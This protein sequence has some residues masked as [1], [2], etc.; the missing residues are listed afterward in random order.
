MTSK[1]TTD[2]NLSIN[3]VSKNSE[4][5]ELNKKQRLHIKNTISLCPECLDKI[6]AE[7]FT[8][9][10]SVYLS[11]Y[12]SNHGTFQDIYWS[13]FE[14]YNKFCQSHVVGT[15]VL[16]PAIK[17]EN[18]L[19]DCGLCEKH[20]TSTILAN[21]DV[22]NRCNL[23]CP[24]C[25]ANAKRSGFIYEPNEEQIQNMLLM[26][27]NQKPVPC[28]AVQF[29]GGEPTVR[30]DLPELISMAKDLDFLHI[31]IATNGV[32]IAKD[33]EFAHKLRTAGLQTV[34]LSF[35]GIGEE[36]YHITRG[37]NA[38]PLKNAAINNCRTA[39]IA[40][41]VLVPTLI[42][43]VNDHQVGNIINF[44][45]ERLDVIKGVNFQPVAFTG[46]IDQTER[47]KKRIT[48]PDFLLM[49]EEQTNGTICRDDWFS[50]PQSTSIS[51][52]IAAM[53]NKQVLQFTIHPHC[54]TVTY[55][56]KDGDKLIPITRFV[57]VDGLFEYLDEISPQ[58]SNTNFQIKKAG[59]TSK[60]LHKIS[61]FIDQKTAPQSIN[62]T[63]MIMDFFN[64]GTG[65]ALK[66][67]HRNSLFLGSMHFQDPYN[68]DIER[69][70]RCGIHYATPDGR[71]IPFCAYNTIHR[72]EVEAKFSKP[73]YS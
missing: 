44:A 14:L 59:L 26:L 13:D 28:C 9:D 62:V 23:N 4:T 12:C 57:D 43:E 15:G 35:D 19:L 30:D 11:K 53:L 58:I 34:Y 55:I 29:S 36:P 8:E 31:Q 70:Q 25:F 27:R 54:G 32:R 64:K 20:T 40:S 48:I 73:F 33:V 72:Q 41:I 39:G 17:S 38:F 24:V 60:A 10:G 50:V 49:T 46:R 56:F 16:N 71:V 68:F 7:I 65:E 66:P 6:P 21:I 61:S 22:T 69:V 37:F 67:F 42:K 45:S 52:F 18:H 3:V 63:K 2:C 47:E 51:R 1:C 5:D